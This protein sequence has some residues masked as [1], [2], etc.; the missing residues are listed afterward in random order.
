MIATCPTNKIRH[1]TKQSAQIHMELLMSDR[2]KTT[3]ED[4]KRLRVY[5]CRACES[6]H[7]GRIRA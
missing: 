1:P 7:V 6:W 2:K 4:R 5:H 3:A